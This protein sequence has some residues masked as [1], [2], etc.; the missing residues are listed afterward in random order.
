MKIFTQNYLIFCVTQSYLSNRRFF[1]Q[2]IILKL[3]IQTIFCVQLLII[4]FKTNKHPLQWHTRRNYTYLQQSGIPTGPLCF[5][6]EMF[7]FILF[8]LLVI[9]IILDIIQISKYELLL[10]LDSLCNIIIIIF[11]F[12]MQYYYY[13]YIDSGRSYNINEVIQ[14]KIVIILIFLLMIEH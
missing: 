4:E 14:L 9:Y 8:K 7:L 11:R 6:L 5:Y 1:L 12:F 13:Y 3:C 2:T 10:C